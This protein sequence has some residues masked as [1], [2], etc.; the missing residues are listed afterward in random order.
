MGILKERIMWT[1]ASAGRDGHTSLE[2]THGFEP[3]L[4]GSSI[5]GTPGVLGDHVVDSL[6]RLSGSMRSV[7]RRLVPIVTGIVMVCFGAQDV[8][9]MGL[10]QGS[11]GLLSVIVGVLDIE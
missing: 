5:F 1:K 3:A 11:A 7:F 9:W 2:R 10:L 4:S 8:R 6:F